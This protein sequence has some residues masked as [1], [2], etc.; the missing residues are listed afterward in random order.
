MNNTCDECKHYN[1]MDGECRK[2]NEM[3]RSCGEDCCC[4]FEI[5][6]LLQEIY[7]EEEKTD[8]GNC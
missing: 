5:D 3:R 8:E 4:D 2:H 7:K 1:L 6:T